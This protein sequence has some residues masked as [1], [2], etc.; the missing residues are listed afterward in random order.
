MNSVVKRGIATVV[1][2]F[3][4]GWIN[5]LLNPVATILTGQV[6]GKQLENSDISYVMSMV[7]MGFF[8]NFGVPFLILLIVLAAI[9]WKYLK[10]GLAVVLG[11]LM[12][13]VLFGASPAQAYY[14]KYDYTEAY[15]ILPN[16]SAFYIP[17]VGANK[18]SQAKFGSEEYLRENKIAAKRFVIPHVKLENSGLM[19][20]YY[21]PA[22]RLIIVDRTPYNREWVDAT[23]R[24]TTVKKEG[25][26]CQSKEGLNITIGISIAASVL[27]E[28]AP[29]FLHRFGVNPP[30]GDRTK[31]EVVF[32]SVFNG[33]SL[34]EVMDTVV[35]SKVQ[36]LACA[37]FTIRTFN[38]GNSSAAAIMQAIQKN[39]DAY[40]KSVGITLDYVG[41]ADTFEF[42]KEVQ[43]AID[44]RYIADKDKEIAA[45]LAPYADTI[46]KLAAADAL[47]SFGQKTDGKLPTTIV[48]LPT[49]IGALLSTLLRSGPIST[50][51]VPV[52]PTK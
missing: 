16:E 27:E 24:G 40:M 10:E 38:E 44:R 39:V 33:K 6:A 48:G 41:W 25:F 13:C 14:D 4:Y 23:D 9:W 18:E 5:F 51:A 17:D 1:V 34:K 50:P 3:L 29:R 30:Q 31:P 49:E 2:L 45:M 42:S 8:K 36:A 15:F 37:E 35:R 26:P 12:L 21:V 32:T 22:G 20:N 11:A 47:R 46:Q 28:N 19:S 52:V 7:G 43:A